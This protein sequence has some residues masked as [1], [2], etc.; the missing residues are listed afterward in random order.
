MFVSCGSRSAA[1]I[2]SLLTA[3]SAPEVKSETIDSR[4]IFM[5]AATQ[6]ENM[7]HRTHT[8]PWS[9]TY[10]QAQDAAG[11]A[12]AAAVNAKMTRDLMR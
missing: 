4:Y 11:A 1:I 8:C 9:S 2:Q 12:T 6:Q 10:P 5:L 7:M 3:A